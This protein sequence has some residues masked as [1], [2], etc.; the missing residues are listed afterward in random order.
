MPSMDCSLKE[1]FALVVVVLYDADLPVVSIWNVVPSYGAVFRPPIWGPQVRYALC[2]P[3]LFALDLGPEND[4][5]S[6]YQNQC[7]KLS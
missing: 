1:L 7:W 4:P 3:H 2:V 5:V 6:G